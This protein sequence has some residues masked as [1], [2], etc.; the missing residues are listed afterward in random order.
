MRESKGARGGEFAA[1]RFAA[2]DDFR[3][4]LAD[5]LMRKI[6]E[7]ANA[8]F[9]GGVDAGAATGLGDFER[10]GYLQI[11][12]AFTQVANAGLAEHAHEWLRRSVENGQFQGVDFDENVINAARIERCEQML[13][14]GEQ[15]AVHHKAGGVADAGDVAAVGFDFEIVKI[16]AAENDAGA[17]RGGEQT[18]V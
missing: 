15:H 3:F 4:L 17:G 16:G 18:E 7:A 9:V 5:E 8:K 10:L 1:K 13:S 12:A 11:L 2:N 6:D 14:G